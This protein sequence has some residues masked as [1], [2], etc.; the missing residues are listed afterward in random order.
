M[1]VILSAVD[2]M[3]GKVGQAMHK[4]R[5]HL[6]QLERSQAYKG[7]KV[8]GTHAMRA[9]AVITAAMG[10]TVVAAEQAATANARLEQVFRSMGETNN[11]AANAAK[12]YAAQLGIQTGVD[13][14]A[15]LLTQAKLATFKEVSNES[16]RMAGVFDRA[17]TAAVDLAAAGF[18]DAAMNAVQLGKALNDPIKGITALNRSGVTFTKTEEAKIKALTQSGRVLEAQNMILSAVEKQVGGVAA[19]TAND[20]D[21]MREAFRQMAEVTGTAL[22]PMVQELTA[23]VTSMV[24]PFRQFIEANPGLIKGIAKVGAALLAFG[25]AVKVITTVVTVMNAVLALNPFVLLAMAIIAVAMLIYNYWDDIAAFFVRL[26]DGIKKVFQVTWDWVK[27]LF[28]KYHPVVLIYNNWEKIVNWFGDLWQRV[29]DKFWQALMFVWN[30]R[31]D[32]REAGINIVTSIWDGMKGKFDQMLNWFG[33]KIQ[34]MRDYLPFSP[35]KIGPLKDIHK[36]KIV[37]TIQQSIKPAGL[38]RSMEQT[39]AVAKGSFMGGLST[40]V[41]PPSLSTSGGGGG[42]ISVSY[43]P[44]INVGGGV[45]GSVVEQITQVM[46]AQKEEIKRIIRQIAADEKRRAM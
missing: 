13:K 45:E 2:N 27:N 41:A 39:A 43:S 3:S 18:G 46:A 31:N 21:K 34:T 8:A 4:A 6:N 40:P 28:I 25:V 42:A 24:V 19:A 36:L 37:E 7:F 32:M 12:A 22:L 5:G 10:G 20:T 44:T 33:E 14:N 17:T 1:E 11:D 35:A 23:Q 38:A 30:F 9:G 26:W 29:K 16:A 15:I